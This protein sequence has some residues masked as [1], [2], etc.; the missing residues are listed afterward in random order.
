[1]LLKGNASSNTLSGTSADDTIYGLGGDD[2]LTG[3]DGNDVLIGDAI[4]TAPITRA[5]TDASGAQLP[6]GGFPSTPVF[7]PDGTKLAY[8]GSYTTG[9]QSILVKD[10][11]TGTLTDLGVQVSLNGKFSFSPDGAKIA[12]STNR[13]LV[14]ADT[15]GSGEDVYV[16][17]LATGG[18]TLVSANAAGLVADNFYS[19]KAQFSPDGTKVLFESNADNLVPGDT[20]GVRDIFLKDLTSGAISR[21]SIGTLDEQGAV[22][23][24]ANPIGSSNAVF[25]ADGTQIAFQ[26]DD[27]LLTNDTPH[28]NTFSQVYVKNLTNNILNLESQYISGTNHFVGNNGDST[29]PEFS[30]DGSHIVFMSSATNFPGGNPLGRQQIYTKDMVHQSLSVQSDVV[31]LSHNVTLANR[32]SYN[33]VF[34]PDQSFILFSSE[35]TNLTASDTNGITTDLLLKI[36]STGDFVDLSQ[37]AA[38]VQGDGGSGGGGPTLQAVFSPDGSM[39]AYSSIA[40]NLVPGDTNF[41]GDIFIATLGLGPFSNVPGLAGGNDMLDGGNGSD[42]LYGGPGNDTLFGGAGH[43][44]LNGGDGNDTLVG[45]ADPFASESDTLDGGNGNDILYVEASDTISGGAGRDFVYVVNSNPIHIDMG[46]TSI[47]WMQSDFG[48]D[49]IDAST[50]TVGVEI[51]SDGGNDTITGSAFDDI[52]WAGSGND[53]VSGGDGNDVIVGDIGADSISGGNGNDSLYVDASDTFIDGG[54]GHDAAYITGGASMTIDLAATHIEFVADFVPGGSDDT[55]DGSG[56]S[57]NLEVYAGAG[58]DAILGGSGNDFLW[59]EAGNDTISG[60]AGNDTLVGGTGADRLTGGPGTDA[61]YGNSGNG[62]D[63]AVDTFVFTPNWGTDFVFD[64]EHGVDKLD[65]TAVGITFANLTLT[66][67]PDGHCYVTFGS[68]LIAVANHTTANLTASDF[69]F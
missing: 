33:P 9:V 65:L 64:F 42:T 67:T 45:N 69:L 56:T 8:L 24:N 44:I 57:A 43:D 60:G 36:L 46:A 10:L 40:D 47:E 5:T 16:K 61:L 66:N 13:S 19:S 6:I 55:I 53:T 62:G 50:Q 7:S 59:G 38:G 28:L 63:G 29:N 1:M 51:Y 2:T 31:D 39:V 54:A 11:L 52:I 4:F 17:D 37:N 3:A 49:V 32:D 14:P 30:P 48:D 25:S 20:N 58:T 68:N 26:S 27:N 41:E 35:A 15:N 22:S 21:V 18:Y 12:F 23:S 34:S